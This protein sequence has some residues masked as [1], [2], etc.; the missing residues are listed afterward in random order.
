MATHCSVLAWGIPWTEESGVY[1]PWGPKER[2]R[3]ERL[4]LSLLFL[5]V[6]PLL[7]KPSREALRSDCFSTS[8]S[9]WKAPMSCINVRNGIF[10][11]VSV[12][13]DVTVISDDRPPVW[14]GEPWGHSR[15]KEYLPSSSQPPDCSHSLWWASRKL[16]S[17]TQDSVP[18]SLRCISKE[19]FQWAQ[20]LVSS[21]T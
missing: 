9:P 20:T 1:S 16:G 15:R 4:T 12:N 2:N 8:S 21:H 17:W 5:H 13:K 7:T 19:W 6:C 10:P 14:T 18:R 11:A 3:T